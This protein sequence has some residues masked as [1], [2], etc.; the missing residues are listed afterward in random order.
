MTLPGVGAAVDPAGPTDEASAPLST[1]SDAASSDAAPSDAAPSEVVPPTREDAIPDP[2][3][4]QI[5][6]ERYR[7]IARI[8][9]GGMA[10]VYEVESLPIKKHLAL[11]LV[12]PKQPQGAEIAARFAREIE[13]AARIEHPHLALAFDG[14]TLPSGEAFLIT[15]LVRGE[16]LHARLARGPIP[17]A[18]AASIASQIAGALA[19]IHEAGYVHRDLTPSNVL[20]SP[21]TGGEPHVFVL[22]LGIAALLESPKRP[23]T[24]SYLTT[25]GTTVGTPGY[26]SPEQAV[27]RPVDGRSDLYGLGLLFF[28][29]VHGRS[30]FDTA[31]P[32]S[33]L[34]TRLLAEE[35][36]LPDASSMPS[37]LYGLAR[38]LLH[39]ERDKRPADA[40]TVHAGFLA[41]ANGG[42]PTVADAVLDASRRGVDDVRA[43]W[44]VMEPKVAAKI[45]TVASRLEA[46]SKRVRA[47]QPTRGDK[48]GI[49]VAFAVGLAM[50]AIVVVLIA[51]GPSDTP[52]PGAL[53][54]GVVTPGE[55]PAPSGPPT[56]AIEPASETEV[57][58]LTGRSRAL[59]EEAAATVLSAEDGAYPRYARL[60]AVLTLARTCDA[61]ITQIDAIVALGDPRAIPALERIDDAPRTGCGRRNRED[62]YTCVREP[63][64]AALDTLRAR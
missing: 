8:G 3:I 39:T 10:V 59:R 38:S 41:Y 47:G 25:R 30:V 17:W 33:V 58:L 18:E 61:R 16:S 15:Q 49:G 45:E 34:A 4:G 22:D 13:A 48:I 27:G 14:G 28:E 7:V 56:E 52:T 21:G 5:I 1:P 60:V 44:Q 6:A 63:V 46:A 62:C 51:G 35:L 53:A 29:M 55:P 20:I 42:P 32:F 36:T 37:P 57:V 23:A 12:D 26:M 2:W 64:S 9:E 54:P 31:S 50:L 11:K 40:T 24:A 19:A 43:R